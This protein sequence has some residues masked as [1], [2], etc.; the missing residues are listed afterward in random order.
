[1]GL[2]LAASGTG[3]RRFP[4]PAAEIAALLGM[5]EV[6]AIDLPIASAGALFGL[7]LAA[8]LCPR[9]ANVLVVATEI[10]SRVI[11]SERE[12]AILFGDGAGACLVSAENGF[13]RIADSVLASDGAFAGALH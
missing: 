3:E 1:V 10:M 4:G 8:D 2:I 12:T 7:A 5:H 11:G 13:A 9:Y 6:P